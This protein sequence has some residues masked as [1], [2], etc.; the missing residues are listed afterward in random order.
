MKVQ[1]VKATGAEQHFEINET[2]FST[3]DQKGLITSGNK[4]FSR[5]SGYAFKELIGSAHNLIRHPDMPR[6]V[7]AMLW[8]RAQ[9]KLPFAGYVKNQ[10]KNGNHYWVFALIE[11]LGE[12]LLSIR[13]KPSCGILASVDSLYQTLLAKEEDAIGNG[14]SP[15][16]AIAQSKKA[17]IAAIEELGFPTYEAFSQHCLNQEIKSRDQ[18]VSKRGLPLF[19]STIDAKA[20]AASADTFEKVQTAYAHLGTVFSDLDTFLVMADEIRK[21]R[22]AVRVIADHFRLNALN[23]NIAATP[24][25]AQGA[26]I[27]TITQFLHTHAGNFSTNAGILAKQAN[28]TTLAVSEI[29]ARLASARI[30]MEMLISFTAE[31]ASND[32]VEIQKQLH[33]MASDLQAAFSSSIQQASLAVDTVRKTLPELGRKTAELFKAIVSF[34]VAQITGLMECA[35]LADPQHLTG[36]FTDLRQRIESAKTEISKSD[37]IVAELTKLADAT[38]PK[39]SK[40]MS[41]LGDDRSES[42]ETSS[43]GTPQAMTLKSTEPSHRQ[44]NVL[45]I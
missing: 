26:T 32:E 28:H 31:M 5:T 7:F 42:P 4:V 43:Q 9:Q 18:L 15:K 17:L 22:N 37:K 38:P 14:Q 29:V 25:G 24:L 44:A 21:G 13:I 6:C 45:A 16:Q 20:S 11:P 2:F 1:T 12:E 39:I 35:R 27:E 33:K 36:M 34:N 23:A 40:V 3:T 8:D 10:A 30:Q 41:S 19:P